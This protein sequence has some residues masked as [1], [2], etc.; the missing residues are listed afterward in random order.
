MVNVVSG[1]DNEAGDHT[2]HENASSIQRL[3]VNVASVAKLD[4]NYLRI[5]SD[6]QPKVLNAW[7]DQDARLRQPREVSSYG[8]PADGC[9]VGKFRVEG[10]GNVRVNGVQARQVFNLTV[11]PVSQPR[12]AVN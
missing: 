11:V 12:D 6:V 7:R 8:L 10:V 4:Y 2:N 5:G 1:L 3:P 9:R